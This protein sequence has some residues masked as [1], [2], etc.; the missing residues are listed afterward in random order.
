MS[1]RSVAS[2]T[3]VGVGVGEVERTGEEDMDPVRERDRMR[4]GLVALGLLNEEGVEAGTGV[5]VGG[6]GGAHC[7]GARGDD[8]DR[9]V[10]RRGS[11]RESRRQGSG[12]GVGKQ[13][14]E[15]AEPS[16]P[17]MPLPPG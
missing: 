6:E 15:F 11:G 12:R 3:G 7:E 9:V 16:E 8:N 13:M 4:R 1:L 14:G 10:G 17:F 2:A 5:G